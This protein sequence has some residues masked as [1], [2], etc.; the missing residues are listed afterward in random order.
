MF[1]PLLWAELTEGLWPSLLHARLHVL[2][3]SRTCVLGLPESA[4]NAFAVLFSKGVHRSPGGD[5]LVLV[6][7]A[8]QRP[9]GGWYTTY[10]G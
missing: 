7:F 3:H 1:V 8:G 9:Q 2:R 4:A 6:I 5:T 10:P